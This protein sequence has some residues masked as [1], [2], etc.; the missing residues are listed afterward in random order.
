MSI[1]SPLKLA[2]ILAAAILAAAINHRY[3]IVHTREELFVS[4]RRDV[5]AGEKIW[6]ADLRSFRLGGDLSAARKS[7]LPWNERALL[8]GRSAVR[9]LASGMLIIRDDAESTAFGAVVTAPDQCSF[10]LAMGDLR[11]FTTGLSIG[12]EVQFV[13]AN[14]G[15]GAA[16]ATFETCGP[17]AVQALDRTTTQLESTASRSHPQTITLSTSASPDRS[18][19]ASVA[20]LMEALADGRRARVVAVEHVR[21]GSFQAASHTSK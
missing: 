17:F 6:L 8:D 2:M 12:D 7:L 15:G 21:R 4:V 19:P 3:L 18:R 14:A 1:P 10:T 11:R 9:D 16:S 13:I 5:R 20:K